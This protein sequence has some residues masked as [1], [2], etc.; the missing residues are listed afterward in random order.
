MQ[1]L[2]GRVAVVTGAG[3]GIGRAM[4]LRFAAE[5][6]TVAI[7][8]IDGA[9]AEATASLIAEQHPGATTLTRAVDVGDAVAVDAFADDA[10]AALG[11]V[12]VLC[13]NAG[14]F[15]G[16]LLWERPAAD[17]D[18]IFDVNVHGVLNNI[19]SFV[20]RMIDQDTDGHIVTTASVAGLF[21]SPFSGPYGV[22]KFAAFAVGETLAHDL[23][24]TGSKLRASVLCPGIV[25]TDIARKAAAREPLQGT[26][27]SEA[28]RFVNGVLL[29]IVDEHGID[30]NLVADRVVDAIRD[31]TFLILT[32]DHH[33]AHITDRAETLANHE[34]PPIVDYT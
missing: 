31:E 16:G 7:A 24:A 34:L 20:P 21:G 27:T 10:F 11:H 8:D 18:F 26:T 1:E 15:V 23:L 32:H 33:A 29:D 13:N 12:D 3:S 14:V 22:S 25:K 2:T 6:M 17:I 19:R 4:A 5:G 28:Q 9:A 30:P